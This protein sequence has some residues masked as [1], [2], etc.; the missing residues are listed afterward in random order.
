MQYS[1][2]SCSITLHAQL[3]YPAL[4]RRVI[5]ALQN[6]HVTAVA[7]AAFQ[8]TAACGSF[9]NRRDHF[10]E[11]TSDWQQ[12]VLEPESFHARVAMSDFESEHRMEILDHRRELTSD[13]RNLTHV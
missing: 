6:Y 12:G 5:V 11:L 10:Q 7:L 2:V 4:A 13:Q 1:T 9:L 3:R 8:V